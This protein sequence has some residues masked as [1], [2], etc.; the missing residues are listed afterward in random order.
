[1]E[2]VS[3]F[4]SILGNIGITSTAEVT[5]VDSIRDESDTVRVIC[6]SS[7]ATISQEV[8]VTVLAGYE[9][10][11]MW[12]VGN[13]TLQSIES[14]ISSETILFTSAAFSESMKKKRDSSYQKL[15][16]KDLVSKIAKRNGLTPKCDMEQKLEH[17]DQ[18]A[19]S[20]MAL[21]QRYADKYN[22]IFN[23]KNGTLIFL[24]KQSDDLP[25]FIVLAPEASDAQKPKF[26]HSRKF[27][28]KSVKVKWHDPKKNKKQEIVV[29]EGKPE[30]LLKI[31]CKN[32]QEAKDLGQAKLEELIAKS[33]TATITLEGQNIIAGGKALCVGFGP[34]NDGKYL[35]TQAE[36]KA[37]DVFTSTI[38]LE[39]AV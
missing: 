4:F 37:T 31:D 39:R 30:Y 8:A 15:T 1:M 17:V 12:P 19:E 36:H 18:K 13:Y 26:R 11:M 14:D 32:K 2:L 23:V 9:E 6:E 22:A 7:T 33:S 16:L 3:P 5:V 20:D 27:Y 25:L 29:G 34:K 10:G 38:E 35:I 21:L 24:S 28:Y